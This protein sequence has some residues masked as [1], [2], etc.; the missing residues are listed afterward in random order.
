MNTKSFPHIVAGVIAAL[1]LGAAVG[2]YANHPKTVVGVYS[3]S[4]ASF[5]ETITLY[6]DGKYQQAE[7]QE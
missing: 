1:G 6:S 4:D 3:Q 7:T 5:S 2:A